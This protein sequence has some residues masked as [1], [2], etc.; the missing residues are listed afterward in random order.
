MGKKLTSTKAI[1]IKLINL[2]LLIDPNFTFSQLIDKDHSLSKKERPELGKQT[3]KTDERLL[4]QIK[5]TNERC[6]VDI[7]ETKSK[8]FKRD[9]KWSILL[10]FFGLRFRI[11]DFDGFNFGDWKL[12]FGSPSIKV[13]HC[14]NV[15]WADMDSFGDCFIVFF[16]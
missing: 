6:I 9:W 14:L 12:C 15:G 11:K 13:E 2:D 1:V 5:Y 16:L 7:S 8:F 3:L 10:M 4:K